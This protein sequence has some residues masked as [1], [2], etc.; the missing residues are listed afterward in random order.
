MNQFLS[1]FNSP[2]GIEL[3]MWFWKTAAFLSVFRLF[4][5]SQ[6][7]AP[8]IA[9]MVGTSALALGFTF[10]HMRVRAGSEAP[11]TAADLR[12]ENGLKLGGVVVLLVYAALLVL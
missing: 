3:T 7:T 1:F 9:C 10:S 5:A 12:M 11:P 8:L 2:R 6:M 4:Y